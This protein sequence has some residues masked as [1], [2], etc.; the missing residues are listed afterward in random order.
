MPEQERDWELAYE[1]LR[2]AHALALRTITDLESE[3]AEKNKLLA[4]ECTCRVIEKCDRCE[5]IEPSS[6]RSK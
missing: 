3:L 1:H 6:W 4:I 2:V 5:V